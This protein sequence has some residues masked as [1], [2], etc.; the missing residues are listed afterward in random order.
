MPIASL[1]KGTL[2]ALTRPEA[3]D[4]EL[5]E[6]LQS[7]L[8]LLT[9]EKIRNGMDAVRARREALMELGG[10]EQVKVAVRDSRHGAA[11]DSLLRDIQHAVRM[12]RNAPGFTVVVVLTLALG[13]GAN[14]A[15]FSTVNA[16]LIRD[17]PFAEPD[18]LVA[19]NKTRDGVPMGP[20]SR[21]DYFDVSDAAT[22]FEGLA[23][24]VVGEITVTGEASP[25]VV[26]L[27]VATWN[28]LPVLGIDPI[29]GRNFLRDEELVG[30]SGS[31]LISHRLWQRR[32]GGDRE[33]VGKTL[34][35]NGEPRT[36]V[37]VVPAGFRFMADVDM[38]LPVERGD[39]F[40]DP[41]R[42]SHSL[43]LVGR[44]KPGVSLAQ[45]QSEVDTIAAALERQYPDT[46]KGKGVVLYDL[47]RY[48][49]GDARTSLYLLMA[50]TALVLLIACGNVAGLLLARGQRRLPEMAMRSALGAPRKR[51]VRQLVTESVFMT[52]VAGIA[53]IGVAVLFQKLLLRLLPLGRPGLPEPSLDVTVL[54]FTFLIS[55]LAGAAVGVIPAV[56]VTSF[57][58]WEEV[59]AISRVSEGRRPSR[60]RNLLVVAQVAISVVLLVG[61]GL[62]IRTMVRLT[63]A[64][65]GFESNNLLVGKVG[66][67]A[68]V[69][70]TAEQRSAFFTTLVERVEALPGVV[71]ASTISKLPIASPMT[72]WP[73]WHADQ[74]RPE[75]GEGELALARW[76]T[77]GYFETIGIPLLRGRGIVATD[78]PDAARVLV[79]SESVADGLFPDQDPIGRMV[80]LGWTDDPYEI[81][82]VVGDARLDGVRSDF[83]WAMYMS[84]AQMGSTYQWLVVRTSGNPLLVSDAVR[85]VIHDMDR[86]V[87]F[88]DPSSMTSIIGSDL[89]GHRTVTT[90]LGVLAA[91][92]LL[93]TSVGLYGVL[94][95]HVNQRMGEFGIRVALGAPM[96]RLMSSVIARGS[97]MVCAGLLS[98]MVISL[99]GTRVMQ[100]LLFETD[101][102]DPAVFLGAAVF[103]GGIA[104]AACVLPAWRASRVNP[105]EV[106]RKE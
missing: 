59:K 69:Y 34:F 55:V 9:D 98:G 4:R 54:L 38:W 43:R 78:G 82:G 48:M 56:R 23:A 12:M 60:M 24:Y 95:F 58:A 8:E 53:G 101:P 31:A 37:G 19:G 27:M 76:A 83:Y 16:A 7:Y 93:L 10:V 84:S 17:I 1:L 61:S 47:Q 3:L 30:G 96:P 103:L 99:V 18:R 35:L 39:Y 79:I 2:R 41:Q 67:R 90:S 13:I 70:E 46:N 86:D 100:E 40:L 89:S 50:T 75:S 32:F 44:L 81:V 6:E 92:A 102:L 11:L 20:V 66:I 91:I 73:I 33:V 64:D 74:P 65:L 97:R 85:A 52:L 94:A 87:V 15:L 45:A 62:L 106:L 71:R 51:L 63:T 22:S 68:A 36:I 28:L 25:E 5:D 42:D 14:T 57:N 88:A 21:L 105:V 29:V 104:L 80:K 49:V 26:G 72:D 77:P